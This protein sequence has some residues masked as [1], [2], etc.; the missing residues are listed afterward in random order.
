MSPKL[1]PGVRRTY[2]RKGIVALEEHFA[3]GQ[4]HGVN[5]G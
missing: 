3:G 4:L 5:G 1:K 2:Y